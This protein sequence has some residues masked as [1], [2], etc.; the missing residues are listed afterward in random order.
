MAK[1]KVQFQK[2]MSERQFVDL[3]GTEEQCR[4][5]FIFLALAKWVRVPEVPG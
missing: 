5:R 1:N 2:G 4:E 3:F